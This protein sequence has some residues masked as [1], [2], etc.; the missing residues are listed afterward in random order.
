MRHHKLKGNRETFAQLWLGYKTFEVRKNDRDYTTG[1][2]VTITEW[3]PG[4]PDPDGDFYEG[5]SMTF[6]IGF[7]MQGV[8]GLPKDVCAFQILSIS[9]AEITRARGKNRKPK[10]EQRKD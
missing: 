6:A 3:D 1:D 5:R 8:Y 2:L 9:Q 10:D 4:D 7:I